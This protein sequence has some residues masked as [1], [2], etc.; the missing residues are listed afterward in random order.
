MGAGDRWTAHNPRPA[1]GLK[2]RV[3]KTDVPPYSGA[4]VYA[5]W[6]GSTPGCA[7]F[8]LDDQAEYAVVIQYDAVVNGLQLT[9]YDRPLPHDAAN[10]TEA[11]AIL[12]T[13]EVGTLGVGYGNINTLTPTYTL[14]PAQGGHARYMAVGA[15]LANLDTFGLP[16]GTRL[17]F[18]PY[19]GDQYWVQGEGD[20]V[21]DDVERPM[22]PTN[23]GK[24][25]GWP[26][27]HKFN[28]AHEL[29][30]VVAILRD[31]GR[32][33]STDAVCEAG[34]TPGWHQ[35]DA[36]GY[37]LPPE[38]GCRGERTSETPGLSAKGMFTKEY[39]AMA[40]REGWADF[41]AAFAY[42]YVSQD[43]CVH[44][45]WGY[46]KNFDLDEDN[47]DLNLVPNEMAGAVVSDYDNAY[48]PFVGAT[49]ND[50]FGGTW[51][52]GW[53]SCDQQPLT[54]ALCAAWGAGCNPT[55]GLVVWDQTPLSPILYGK[56]WL[57]DVVNEGVCGGTLVNRSS[58]YDW[59]RFYWDLATQQDVPVS[60]IADLVNNMDLRT[61]D[62]DDNDPVSNADLDRC[63]DDGTADDVTV[64]LTTAA[65]NTWCF[66]CPVPGT[67]TD[68]V[69]AEENNG[70]DH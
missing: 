34:H 17:E 58:T 61:A 70:Q 16:A 64:R 65:A 32:D 19:L 55:V 68:E 2:V 14:A 53:L 62:P 25:W 48:V 39:Q 13:Y 54:T 69:A 6:N 4:P 41:V 50:V 45:E 7:T 11:S 8:S 56:D 60:S 52:D 33:V 43:D 59:L 35:E 3:D 38:D 10:A 37:G 15:L 12:N 67:L 20:T 23:D 24:M 44:G 26:T 21:I 27:G 28:V 51:Q 42:N 40:A 47:L 49:A 18:Y 57:E 9:S 30:H 29:G 22:N 1:R 66:G 31:E 46:V 63:G 5:S 36:L